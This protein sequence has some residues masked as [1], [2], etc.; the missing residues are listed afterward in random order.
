VANPRNH[1]LR[2][3]QHFFGG[4][5]EMLPP[6]CEAQDCVGYG[7]G[8]YANE[9][10][11]GVSLCGRHEDELASQIATCGIR[12]LGAKGLPNGN[13]CTLPKAHK[14]SHQYKVDGQLSSQ[15]DA[16]HGVSQ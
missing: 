12:Q 7:H 5:K 3:V 8:F 13:V 14:G 9:N 2:I 4:N 11:E 6:P 10:R 1:N 15:W 16:A